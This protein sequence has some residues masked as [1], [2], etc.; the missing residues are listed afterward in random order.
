MLKT[1]EQNAMKIVEAKDKELVLA[2]KAVAAE[3]DKALNLQK[4][5]YEYWLNKKSDDMKVRKSTPQ[6]LN[7]TRQTLN[8]KP[9]TPTRK[10]VNPTP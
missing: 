3:K 5:Q 8:P 9:H 1:A 6:T 2:L 4:E 7:P 10:P